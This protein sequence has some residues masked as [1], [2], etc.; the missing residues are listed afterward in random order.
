MAVDLEA[1]RKRVQELNGQRR[2]S[3]VQLWKPG[4]GK[5][6]VRG[7]PW[8]AGTAE[9]IPFVERRFYYIGNNPGILAPFQFNK[10][11][12]INDLIRKLYSSGKP[13][14]RLLAK[15]LG[16]KM[17]AYLP[18]IVRGQEDKGV[19]VW[20]FGKMVYQRLLDFYTNTDVNPDLID[21]LDPLEGLDLIVTIAQAPG[22]QFMDTTVDLGRKQT[23]L[24]G[25]PEQMKKWVD[26][27]PNIDDMYRQKSPQ[28]IEKILNDWLAGGGA[29]DDSNGNGSDG[30]SRGEKPKD[31]LD[32]LVDEVKA[33]VK[34]PA[35]AEPKAEAKGKRGKKDVDVDDQPSAKKQ[36]LD[37]AF[38]ELMDGDE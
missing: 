15:K 14:D 8:K 38:E 32:Q 1:I 11:D 12:P 24:H 21:W 20:S 29:E 31:A 16:S 36:S 35:K 34:S 6:N 13:D 27:V 37:E 2:N 26:G 19:Q 17:R 33:E 3:S 23:K 30:S 4:A 5:Y 25:D 22:K 7:V 18:V 28:E 10:P 9:G